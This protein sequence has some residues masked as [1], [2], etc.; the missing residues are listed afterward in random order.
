MGKNRRKAIVCFNCKVKLKQDHNYCPNCGQENHDKRASISVL[1]NDFVNDYVGFDN[2]LFRSLKPLLFNPG[3][4]TAEYLDGKRKHF[5]RPI[6]M[7][8]FLSFIY[9]GLSLF[10]FSDSSTNLAVNDGA[11]TSINGREFNVEYLNEAYKEHI[12]LVVF[13]FTP[14]MAWFVMLIY[15]TEKR[16]YYVDFFVY[17]LHFLSF[18]FILGIIHETLSWAFGNGD[19]KFDIS[20]YIL[21][22]IEIIF[23]IYII[24]YSIL[25][26]KRV[27]QKKNNILLFLLVLTM[28]I[29]GLAIGFIAFIS[30]LLLGWYLGFI[31]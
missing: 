18:L 30:L 9:Y 10:L 1:A 26:L 15:R 29:I 3:K 23:I 8:L 5:I 19:V 13:I 25:S 21:L 6:R 27:F 11:S 12:N 16:K 4:I 28:S 31:G 2:K 17:T 7:F 14:L 20:N 22:A 24:A